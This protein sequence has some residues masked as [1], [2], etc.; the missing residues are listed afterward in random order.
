LT[1]EVTVH[2]RRRS[3]FVVLRR[4]S[5]SVAVLRRPSPSFVVLRRI[6]SSRAGESCLKNKL[7]NFAVRKFLMNLM[8][9]VGWI[10]PN[11][12]VVFPVQSS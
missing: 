1:V 5:S 4:L 3:S 7:G 6:S 12:N 9:V 11:T 2:C 10:P 8:W